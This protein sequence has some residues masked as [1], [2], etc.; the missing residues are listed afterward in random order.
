MS[1]DATLQ[2]QGKAMDGMLTAA[3]GYARQGFA[4]FPCLPGKKKPATLHGCKDATTDEQTIRRWWATNPDC[5][6]AIATN[7]ILV[8]DIDDPRHEWAIRDE[9]PTGTPIAETPRGGIHAYFAKPTGIEVKNWTGI[10]GAVDTRTDGLYVVASPS[11]VD[12]PEKNVKGTYTWFAP[13]CHR[14]DLPEAPD[15]VREAIHDY[16]ASK[17]P[18]QANV[19]HVPSVL[20][21]IVGS[22]AVYAHKALA[23]EINAAAT[24]P[25]GTRNDTLNCAAFKIGQL[26]AA[27]VVDEGHARQAFEEVALSAGLAEDEIRKTLDSAFRAGKKQP[28]DLSHVGTN[29]RASHGVDVSAVMKAIGSTTAEIPAGG[30]PRQDTADEQDGYQF[31]PIA[32]A[33]FATGD[34]RQNFLVK[35]VL[36]EGE[37]AYIAGPVKSLKTTLAIDLALSLTSCTR[38]LGEFEVPASR[39]VAIISGESGKRTV[40]ETALRVCKTKGIDLAK[41]G[42]VFEFNLPQ[43][44]RTEDVAALCQ[45]L[46]KNAIQVLI[47]DPLYL[48]LL[49]G[50]GGGIDEKSVFSMGEHL[51]GISKLCQALGVT[52]ILVHH[53]NRQIKAGETMEL[54]HLA[55]AGSAEFARQWILL[56]RETP[57]AG[58][59]THR[60]IMNIGGS[61]GHGGRYL[62]SI[63]EGVTDEHFRGRV[64]EVEVSNMSE[65]IREAQATREAAKKHKELEKEQAE[66]Q[67]VMNAVDAVCKT[68]EAA[69]KSEIKDMAG[70]SGDRVGAV[71]ARL[72]RTGLLDQV[73]FPKVC[74]T[75]TRN[76]PGYQRPRS[77]HDPDD[78]DDP[79]RSLFCPDGPSGPEADQDDP[80]DLDKTPR[81]GVVPSPAQSGS[82]DSDPDKPQK[83]TAKNGKRKAKPKAKAR[84][85]RPAGVGTTNGKIK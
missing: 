15:Y 83:T 43:L 79:D 56:N 63:T 36:V 82:C 38:F 61:A 70:M 30:E 47:L 4:V 20:P 33:E 84:K 81:R 3:I 85:R 72:V 26:V 1:I 5:N 45:G 18:Q 60:I 6:V 12:D 50:S 2:E 42:C 62:A 21:P 23:A 74:G 54:Q 16:Q 7:G 51:R 46:Q 44:G 34:Y 80:D 48:C 31:R 8:V 17:N 29:G 52:P 77:A 78:A 27:G 35:N 9:W 65:A 58:D 73:T 25:E 10:H 19:V 59:G 75:A 24:A 40:Q 49:A 76:L 64:W 69:T 71:L 39:R 67:K 55:F 32:A 37:P 13:L 66:D 41:Q 28:R 57:Y 14:D 11:Y 53:A 22:N 68:H